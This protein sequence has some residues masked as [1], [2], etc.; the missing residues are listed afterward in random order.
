MAKPL[1]A[2]PV[3]AL[4]GLSSFV[5]T[6]P[7]F[8]AIDKEQI[9][10]PNQPLETE[11]DAECFLDK[12]VTCGCSGQKDGFNWAIFINGAWY[13][14]YWRDRAPNPPWTRQVW[15]VYRLIPQSCDGC[16]TFPK[17]LGW[18]WCWE[19]VIQVIR[20]D[21]RQTFRPMFSGPGGRVVVVGTNI[22]EAGSPFQQVRPRL[23]LDAADADSMTLNG[24]FVEEWRDKSTLFQ[25]ASQDTPANQPELFPNVVNGLPIVRFTPGNQTWMD[26][27]L[28]NQN[29]FHLFVVG[30]F[31]FNAGLDQGVFLSA[32]GFE[33]P[34]SGIEGGVFQNDVV[35]PNGTIYTVIDT[36]VITPVFVP[37]AVAGSFAIFEWAQRSAENGLVRLGLNAVIE[38][39]TE[40]DFSDDYWDNQ[41]QNFGQPIPLM[42][43]LGRQNQGINPASSY[44]YLDG[45]IG[46]V[47][48]YPEVLS[49]G[50]RIQ[51]LN[52]LRS[53]W[54][55][56][57]PL[58]L[59]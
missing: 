24:T 6:P 7:G 26:V 36:D 30:R 37:R 52:V 16:P 31:N 2:A 15:D 56:G 42:G 49:E 48:L 54:N 34:F 8:P 1:V 43:A 38:N 59:P 23:W 29:N 46:E 53:K 51:V 57:A 20:S 45:D 41:R 10:A 32:A 9:L 22:F 18:F 21:V 19:D 47:L 28:R 33:A 55:L 40:G 35:Q 14:V 25:N 58:G 4:P 3:S 11:K 44:N 50:Q 5:P 17:H 39:T 12:L 13:V 27:R